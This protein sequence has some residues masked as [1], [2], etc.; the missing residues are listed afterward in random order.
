MVDYL[1]SKKTIID[2][3]YAEIMFQLYEAISQKHRGKLSLSV[4]LLHDNAPVHK[5]LVAQQAVRN[6]VFLQ[7][8]HPAYSP[9]LAPSNC[10]QF[11][12]L[13]PHLSG[14]WF[15]DDESPKVL[16][17][18]GLKGKTKNSFSR[19]KQLTRK[20]TNMH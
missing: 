19:H 2:H 4:S 18:H 3:N 1:P 12:N 14:T 16:L 10:H 20:A 17:K 11:R 6:C 15:A 8:N 5:S 13:K 7:L 9:E